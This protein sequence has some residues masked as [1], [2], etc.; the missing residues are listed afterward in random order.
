MLKLIYRSAKRGYC[1]N[2]AIRRGEWWD[3]RDRASGRVDIDV[4]FFTSIF[5]PATSETM[6]EQGGAGYVID[7]DPPPYPA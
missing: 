2:L 1:A 7:I 3:A 4:P 5:E 6:S